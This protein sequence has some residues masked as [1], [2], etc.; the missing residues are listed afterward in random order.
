MDEDRLNAIE[1]ALSWVI[2]NTRSAAMLDQDLDHG[3]QA[4][5]ESVPPS[6]SLAHLERIVENARRSQLGQP[7]LPAPSARS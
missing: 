4:G 1:W 5:M 6:A 7:L 3:F 2:A